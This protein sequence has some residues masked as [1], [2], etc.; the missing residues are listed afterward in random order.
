MLRRARP[1]PFDDREFIHGRGDEFGQRLELREQRFGNRF[2]VD[3]GQG[4][5]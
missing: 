5:K 2:R 3:A 4:L 1:Y